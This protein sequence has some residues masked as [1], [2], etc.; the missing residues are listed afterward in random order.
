MPQINDLPDLTSQL[1]GL[2]DL[3]DLTDQLSSQTQSSFEDL[4]DLTD[5]LA[6]VKNKNR[7]I[8]EY[9]VDTFKP[10]VNSLFDIGKP[11]KAR[12]YAVEYTG[13][14]LGSIENQN[15]TLGKMYSFYKNNPYFEQQYEN[16]IDQVKSFKQQQQ[17]ESLINTDP[18][19]QQEIDEDD[20]QV[21]KFKNIIQG[22]GA[23]A[24]NMLGTGP[25]AIARGRTERFNE[26]SEYA[27]ITANF[28]KMQGN[29]E[30]AQEF[31]QFAQTFA[32]KSKANMDAYNAMTKYQL[33]ILNSFSNQKERNTLTF[34]LAS[35]GASLATSL[36]IAYATKNPTLSAAA[37]TMPSAGQIYI[38]ALDS[39]MNTDKA[40][41]VALL[42]GV[43]LGALERY[44][45]SS[46]LKGTS[47]GIIQQAAKNFLT[48]GSEELFQEISENTIRRV[49][50][51]DSQKV[52]EN[53]LTA[54]LMGGFLGAGAGGAVSYLDVHL[55]NMDV[56]IEDRQP[57][58]NKLFSKAN[59]IQ[60]QINEQD[61]LNFDEVQA[62]IM[63]GVRSNIEFLQKS[64]PEQIQQKIN[65]LQNIDQ[66]QDKEQVKDLRDFENAIRLVKT[67]PQELGA[68][69]ID[70]LSQK[71]FTE[72]QISI[73][74][75]QYK[76]GVVTLDE[77]RQADIQFQ[78]KPPIAI[79]EN[80][81]VNESKQI[82][83]IGKARELMLPYG[84][85]P[86]NIRGEFK[87]QTEDG[88]TASGKYQDG[89]IRIA[90]MTKN[91]TGSHEAFHYFVDKF[92]NP[93]LYQSAANQVKTELGLEDNVEIEE[94]LAEKF[95]DYRANKKS[96]KGETRNLFDSLMQ[97]FKKAFGNQDN[98][99]TLFKE[100]E[101]GGKSEVTQKSIQRFQE[102][103][104]Q[105]GFNITNINDIRKVLGMKEKVIESP[106]EKLP[107]KPPTELELK[108]Y[109][110][111]IL[112]EINGKELPKIEYDLHWTPTTLE[113]QNPWT[114]FTT[115]VMA[116]ITKQASKVPGIRGLLSSDGRNEQAMDL[117]KERMRIADGVFEVNRQKFIEP[118]KNL[119][120]QEKQIVTLMINK[121]LT[122]EG[123]FEGVVKNIDVAIGQLSN[124]I[125]NMSEKWVKEGLIQPNEKYLAAETMLENIGRYA[126]TTYIKPK[127]GKIPSQ[128]F[129]AAAAN[130]I[131]NA[132]FKQKMSLVDW[133]IRA[134][135][136]DGKTDTEI[137]NYPRPKLEEIGLEAKKLNG[138]NTQA[139]VVLNITF[140]DMVH[141]WSTMKWMEAIVEDETLF[142][143]DPKEGFIAVKNLLPRGAESR[144]K[145]LGPLNE[146]YIHPGLVTDIK[147]LLKGD[148]SKVQKIIGS[149]IGLWKISKTAGS[150][151]A[152]MRN[153]F[154]GSFIQTDL[155]GAPVW[156][157]LNTGTYIKS[158][159]QY[160]TK[161]PAYK[162]WAEQGLYGAD[163]FST[164][165][166]DGF[167]KELEGINPDVGDLGDAITEKFMN[168]KNQVTEKTKYYGMIDHFA[169][170]YLAEW[171]QSKGATPA[172]A[173]TF[174]NKWQLDYRIV[175][176]IIDTARKG[177]GGF[178][179]PF[180][181]FYY[182]MAPRIIETAVG[183]PWKMAKY[184]AIFAG[185]SALA[186]GILG[187]T[188]DEEEAL[189]PKWLKER[190]SWTILLPFTDDNGNPQ[191]LDLSYT[192]PFGSNWKMLY[193]DPADLVNMLQGGGPWQT[194]QNVINNYDAFFGQPITRETDSSATKLKKN[195][196]Y[197]SRG[198]LPGIFLDIE[199]IIKA[200]KKEEYG[201]PFKFERSL[202]QALV[203]P[204][205]LSVYPGGF[206]D[207]LKKIKD[208]R[209][210]A[211]D[212]KF[213]M[214]IIATN[215]N[216]SEKEKEKQIKEHMQAIEKL[217]ENLI[218]L[219][220][221]K[222]AA[223]RFRPNQ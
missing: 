31:D 210:L 154:S 139:D 161:G 26:I 127:N 178:I 222:P 220:K 211:N 120:L 92:A 141:N 23:F 203:K 153:F 98:V 189:K 129:S 201:Y 151:G 121:Y 131:Q 213:Q 130:K 205:G 111:Q 202:G 2:Q 73:V 90:Q 204:L 171:A 183:R 22:F 115:D 13:S 179:A 123:K 169:R 199:R 119:S 166:D 164:E 55:N 142:S 208:L 1:S 39:G 135:E 143:S 159:K 214:K 96:A 33:D 37:L 46:I 182:L 29:E 77:I 188:H 99:K 152:M 184:T 102:F 194:I 80:P 63:P 223:D 215:N 6:P 219:M 170:T 100:F 137:K 186:R 79:E 70:L 173:V 75:E 162:F 19:K 216:L 150:P 149:S 132:M 134:L 87:I 94:Y 45:V 12:E 17:K 158:I 112:K 5:Q 209:S 74:Q 61:F 101:N 145:R 109:Q 38:D 86:E 71:G 136:F 128:P 176:D 106:L 56:P 82:I 91:T 66:I 200:L 190:S 147:G 113:Y 118:L 20:K 42:T 108:A 59:E 180:A 181:S 14:F 88:Q 10:V 156:N 221:Y 72:D 148:I 105:K 116:K 40:G 11:K 138:W 47:K 30:L 107:Y 97:S 68:Q 81:I 95:A 212:H 207:F 41:K 140:K 27:Q 57:I 177:V 3:P 174:A 193:Q 50:V 198:L 110:N 28:A 175:P 48:E 67:A 155:A 192:L 58:I 103:K 84:V 9:A 185:L 65:Q 197:L 160:L 126:R 44:G 35:G 53:A 32:K 16:V 8:F 172:Q 85:K 7:N 163:Y 43:T 49:F 117:F 165:I 196:A 133:G 125:A 144:D 21:N 25:R 18:S 122:P 54:G 187:L 51:D 206:N 15:T 52:F 64:N 78:S 93:S 60:S 195:A 217:K 191:W 104:K 76:N 218:E 168:L 146:G 62:E 69:D 157:P 24:V 167:I 83:E 36:A 114:R 124:D 4:P 34:K 89:I